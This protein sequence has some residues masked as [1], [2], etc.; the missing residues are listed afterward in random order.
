MS[1]L[2]ISNSC[3]ETVFESWKIR[4]KHRI[5]A[6]YLSKLDYGS[7]GYYWLR[8]AIDLITLGYAG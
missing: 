8:D 5:R 3:S 6:S 4:L 2:R 7:L 1:D